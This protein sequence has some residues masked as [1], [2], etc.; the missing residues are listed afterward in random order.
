VVVDSAAAL[1]GFLAGVEP[2]TRVTV[3]YL[4]GTAQETATLV[5]APPPTAVPTNVP[6]VSPP[7]RGPV[8]GDPLAQA[9]PAADV[10]RLEGV[11]HYPQIEAPEQV[12]KAFFDFHDRLGTSMFSV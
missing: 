3:S 11:G 10:V 12:G 5:T 6:T 9:P 1:A 2:G 7:A 4:R 8:G